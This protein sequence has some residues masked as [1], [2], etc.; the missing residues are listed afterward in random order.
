MKAVEVL[1]NLAEGLSGRIDPQ[2]ITLTLTRRLFDDFLL[3]ND[4]EIAQAVAYC[5]EAHGEMVEGAAAVGLAALLA[6]KTENLGRSVGVL[7]TGGNITPDQHRDILDR[8]GV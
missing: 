6:G 3:V 1:P 5:Y 8:A 2:S 4:D 7:I